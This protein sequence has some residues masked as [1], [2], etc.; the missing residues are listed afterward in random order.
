MEGTGGDNLCDSCKLKDLLWN[1]DLNNVDS[2]SLFNEFLEM[3]TNVFFFFFK[4][5]AWIH[6]HSGFQYLFLKTSFC[7]LFVFSLCLVLQFSFTTIF[8]AAFPL[9]PLLA[10]LNNIIEIRMDAIKMVSLE[11]RLVPRKTNDIGES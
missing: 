5:A 8:V 2:F 9:A 10:L 1:F 4:E 6:H 7:T 11:R 3:G